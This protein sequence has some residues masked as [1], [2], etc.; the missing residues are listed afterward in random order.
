[1]RNSTPPEVGVNP[2]QVRGYVFPDST[3]GSF[4]HL[5]YVDPAR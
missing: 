1:M 3:P 2:D 5:E 4:T